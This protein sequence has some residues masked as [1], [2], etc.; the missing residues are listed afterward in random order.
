M[1]KT[2]NSQK[3][4][5]ENLKCSKYDTAVRKERK[6]LVARCR[7]IKK[8]VLK[9]IRGKQSGLKWLGVTEVLNVEV[10]SPDSWVRDCS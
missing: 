1:Q 4:R 5:C 8:S 2:V 10:E 3:H 6:Q 9:L 7:N